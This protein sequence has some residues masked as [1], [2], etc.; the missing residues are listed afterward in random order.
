MPSC[1][2]N[3]ANRDA[4]GRWLESALAAGRGFV[5]CGPRQHPGGLTQQ[6]WRDAAIASTTEHGN[7]IVTERWNA[8]PPPLADA[9]SQAVAVAALRALRTLEPARAEHWQQ[10]LEALRAQI[11]AT[12][13]PNVMAIDGND[14][15]VTGAG[16]QLGWLLW[17]GALNEDGGRR[18]CC[19]VGPAR[20]PDPVRP[21]HAIGRGP[22]HSSALPTIGAGSG[23]STTGSAGWGC[24]RTVSTR[25]PTGCGTESWRHWPLGPLSGA[26]RRHPVRRTRINPNRQPSSGMDRRRRRGVYQFVT[27]RRGLRITPWKPPV[28]GWG[29]IGGRH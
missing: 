19:P 8:P 2:R 15:Q 24:R 29:I 25:R 18:R 7:G 16:S 14:R 13:T 23:R 21:A 4:A 9:D 26:V 20:H 22:R 6:G 27:L 3:S 5:R 1:R 28:Q 17:A 10:R 11:N 12:F